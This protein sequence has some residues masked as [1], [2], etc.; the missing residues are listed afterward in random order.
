MMD[1]DE[2]VVLVPPSPDDAVR[3]MVTVRTWYGYP[4]RKATLLSS[5]TLNSLN[6]NTHARS[7]N[8]NS[9]HGSCCWQK[10]RS[11]LATTTY[12]RQSIPVSTHFRTGTV[13]GYMH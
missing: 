6:N 5:V 7:T 9:S 4:T 1:D 11:F 3:I 8:N 13:L 2:W 10:I 12:L